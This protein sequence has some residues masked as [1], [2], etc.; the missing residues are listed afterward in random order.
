M[1]CKKCGYKLED[2]DMF[3]PKCGVKVNANQGQPQARPIQQPVQERSL[4]QR[5]NDKLSLKII[6]PATII[7]LFLIVGFI[8]AS[9]NDDQIT[10]TRGS[11]VSS[12]SSR[13]DSRDSSDS[14]SKNSVS[15][16]AAP[17]AGETTARITEAE[18]TAARVTEAETTTARVTEAAVTT[19]RVT[20]PPV[21]EE[22][23][24]GSSGNTFTIPPEGYA[25]VLIDGTKST[26]PAI[27]ENFES[28]STYNN[29]DKRLF[30]YLDG[31]SGSSNSQ[32]YICYNINTTVKDWSTGSRL[33]LDDMNSDTNRISVSGY[34]TQNLKY[35]GNSVNF[36]TSQHNKSLF[37]E[38]ELTVIDLNDSELKFYF[39]LK[40]S[41]KGENH[42]F[43]GVGHVILDSNKDSDSGSSGSSGSFSLNMPTPNVGGTEK[44]AV[45]KGTAVCNICK[46]K[47]KIQG[48]KQMVTCTSCHGTTKCTYCKGS[49]YV[50]Y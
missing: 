19:K 41:P 24:K 39:N 13:N 8:S 31:N 25:Q 7:A 47:G 6:V 49:G 27:Y 12:S 32:K 5:I 9:N 22:T 29:Y 4:I 20:E 35:T 45:C 21:K 50:T 37:E 23:Y 33:Y 28:Q 14:N 18:T 16:T 2:R 17:K 11:S 30:V 10:Q 34:Y 26:V 3:C 1:F 43:E 42:T 46:G 48:W 44:C 15:T 36:M 40:I 38:S